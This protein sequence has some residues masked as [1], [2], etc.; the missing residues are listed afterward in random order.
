MPL[1][2]GPLDWSAIQLVVFDVDGTLYDQ[3]AMRL[4]MMASL[5]GHSIRSR[6]F[7]VPTILRAFRK[8]REELAESMAPGFVDR[9]YELTAS[10]CGCDA[11][12][13][14]SVVDEW[15]ER[16]PLD[17]LRR[18]RFPG[19]QD[20]FRGA[21]AKNKT[22]GIL[23]DYPAREK[24]EKLGLEA[25]VIV[26]ATDP[27]VGFLKPHPQGLRRLIEKAG[28]AP[29]HTIMIGDRP[30]RDWAAADK[31]GIRALI[32]SKRTIPGVDT[33]SSYTDP[34]FRGLA[35]GTQQ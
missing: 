34:V 20:I 29:E 35:M 21:S 18:C 15:M 27:D 4:S 3:R 26:S 33:F 23:S 32:R 25:G 17:R 24:L 19:L 6:S 10:Q 1:V 5:L 8:L 30:E 9:Q 16:R 22:I 11:S 12:R 31:L 2:K 7:E 13:V 28:V 14:R